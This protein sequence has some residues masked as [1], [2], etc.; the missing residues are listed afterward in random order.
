MTSGR[1]KQSDFSLTIWFGE[2][3]RRSS[4]EVAMFLVSASRFMLSTFSRFARTGAWN[5][6][7][8]S[9]GFSFRGGQGTCSLRSQEFRRA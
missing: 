3:E 6:M 8:V 5:V 2:L 7:I 1:E 9:L 4:Q